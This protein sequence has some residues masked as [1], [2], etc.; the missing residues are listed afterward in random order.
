MHTDSEAGRTVPHDVTGDTDT[1]ET[2]DDR[3]SDGIDESSSAPTAR[4]RAAV[5]RTRGLARL[6]DDAVRVP[7]TNFRVGLDP[8][9][10]IVPVAGDTVATLFALYPIAEAIRFGLPTSTILKMVLFVAVDGV[11]GSVPVLGT[12]FDAFWKANRWNA[13]TLE[14]HLQPE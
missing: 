14:R 9:T 8:I 1:A 2:A 3:S 12:A 11:V 5:R 10:G 7:G 6:L 13:R 4:E